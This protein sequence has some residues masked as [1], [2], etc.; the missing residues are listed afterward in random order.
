MGVLSPPFLPS[1]DILSIILLQKIIEE[2]KNYFL[3]KNEE[4]SEK[5]CLDELNRIS[6]VLMESLSAGTFSV[7]GGHRLYMEAREKVEQDYLQVPRK[8]VKVR[9]TGTW[10]A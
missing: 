1:S 4:T 7:P 9:S 6:K 8:G 3:L 5:Y 2:K 10:G